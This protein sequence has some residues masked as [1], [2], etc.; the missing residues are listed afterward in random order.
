M[1]Y[2]ISDD[3]VHTGLTGNLICPKKIFE[4]VERH[5]ARC[6]GVFHWTVDECATC[7]QRQASQWQHNIA[8]WHDDR[9]S[10]ASCQA[11]QFHTSGDGV[12]GL[13]D[14]NRIRTSLPQ[15]R[16]NSALVCRIFPE[17]VRRGNPASATDKHIDQLRRTL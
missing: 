13:G 12:T 15:G 6:G 7:A 2:R 5:L 8:H 14:F 3:A 11:E 4:S 17:E 10:F 1:S 16:H 9:V